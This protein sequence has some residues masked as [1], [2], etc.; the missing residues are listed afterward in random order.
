MYMASGNASAGVKAAPYVAGDAPHRMRREKTS[1][2]V[3]R[4]DTAPDSV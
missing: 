1:T 2:T 4:I 3:A